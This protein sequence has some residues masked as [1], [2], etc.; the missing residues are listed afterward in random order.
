RD[1]LK[2]IKPGEYVAFPGPDSE[3]T[4]VRA[5]PLSHRR[6]TDPGFRSHG[7][8]KPRSRSAI[9][10]WRLSGGNLCGADELLFSW[11]APRI[12]GEPRRWPGSRG[13]GFPPSL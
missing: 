1:G 12:A 13:A 5:D 10:G 3:W 8:R 2:G 7:L 11:A 9:H 6:G 4:A